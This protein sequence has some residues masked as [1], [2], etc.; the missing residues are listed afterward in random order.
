MIDS[1]PLP[2]GFWHHGLRRDLSGLNYLMMW[3]V[4]Y[5]LIFPA[6]IFLN[7][8]LMSKELTDL[9]PLQWENR[10]L[11]IECTLSQAPAYMALL[12]NDRLEIKDRDIVWFILTEERLH[13]NYTGALADTFADT[14]RR[15]VYS[16]QEEF[17]PVLVIGKDGGRK[18][19]YEELDLAEIYRLIDSMPMRQ[20]EM[21]KR[22]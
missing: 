5:S 18:A 21:R 13:T 22:Y 7:L 15:L 6:L 10:I 12:E 1:Q 3:L 11:L 16:G 19:H 2:T 9:Q 14:L 8:D 4:R 20:S 17:G